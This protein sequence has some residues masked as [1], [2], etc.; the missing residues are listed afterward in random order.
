MI[1]LH[2]HTTASDG[3]LSPRA[4]VQRAAALDVR[5]LA[6]TDHDTVAGLPEAFAAGREFGVE[7]I[8]GVEFS[9]EYTPGTMHLL[10]YGFAPDAPGL[11]DVLAAGRRRR[12]ERN[13]QVAA[14]LRALGFDLSLEEVEAVA[15]G[16][17]VG[18]PHFA[19]VMMQKGY[20]ASIDEAFT[21]FLNAGAPAHVKSERIAPAK[22][23]A[24]VQQAGG[25]TILAHPYQLR[26]SDEA[27]LEAIVRSL[28]DAGLAGIEVYYS[29]HRPEQTR[30]YADL[31]RRYDLLMTGGSDFHGTPKPDIELGRGCGDLH[32]PEEV[33]DT[34][35]VRLGSVAV[36]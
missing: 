22:A 1:D 11:L 28:R 27:A 26:A 31:A 14:K 18:R 8:A 6:V 13:P 23:I 2:A 16:G 24:A 9:A 3:S 12:D 32:V 10:G 25:V 33:L 4:L 36:G 7:I 34:L 17:V 5:T 19:Q 15:A 35:K 20:V 29:R 21:R 30:L